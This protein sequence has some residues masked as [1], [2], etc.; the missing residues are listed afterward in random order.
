MHGC[1]PTP[2]MHFALAAPTAGAYFTRYKITKAD[3]P[4]GFKLL[5]LASG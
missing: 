4:V 2:P 5:K 3:L 1:V